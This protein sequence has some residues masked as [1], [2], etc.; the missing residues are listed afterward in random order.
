MRLILVFCTAVFIT[1]P[2]L[3]ETAGVA[4][5]QDD[6]FVTDGV[7]HE[8]RNLQVFKDDQASRCTP[9][10]VCPAQSGELETD[11]S[12]LRAATEHFLQK[13]PM[14]RLI[15]NP[16][17]PRDYSVSINHQDCKATE[18]GLYKV[19]PG[20]TRVR[21]ERSGKAPCEWSGRLLQGDSQEI[22]CNL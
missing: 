22:L 20:L 5:D 16:A 2:A 9:G 4:Q 21:V 18:K 6:V 1:S 17:P 19:L 8:L 13:Y 14:I 15:V 7:L 12:K 10:S 3:P 11:P